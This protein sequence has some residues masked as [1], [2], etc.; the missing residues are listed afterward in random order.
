MNILKS[1]NSFSLPRLENNQIPSTNNQIITNHQ[2][3]MN[4]N[5]LVIKK[6]NLFGD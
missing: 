5:N 1:Y 2:I 4:K 3:P 6:W